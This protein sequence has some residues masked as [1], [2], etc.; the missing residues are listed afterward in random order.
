MSAILFLVIHIIIGVGLIYF[1][2]K[3]PKAITTFAFTFLV[4]SFTYFEQS[5]Q[6]YFYNLTALTEVLL[7][8]GVE[9]F[10]CANEQV[11]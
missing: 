7:Q 3:L 8:E 6:I 10:C 9:S 1:Y 2:G 5:L 4:M 11:S